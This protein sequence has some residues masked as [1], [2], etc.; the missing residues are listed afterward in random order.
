[1]KSYKLIF[2]YY[3]FAT[4]YILFPVSL[5][6]EYAELSIKSSFD[7]IIKSQYDREYSC[8]DSISKLTL[9]DTYRNNIIFFLRDYSD[10]VFVTIS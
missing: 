1:M 5:F 10:I 8:I 6:A 2:F 4:F 3:L 9:K 7:V